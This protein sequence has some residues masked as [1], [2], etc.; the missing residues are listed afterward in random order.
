MYVLSVVC[1]YPVFLNEAQF[2]KGKNVFIYIEP[3]VLLPFLMSWT[4]G[5]TFFLCTH[6]A[7]FQLSFYFRFA[8]FEMKNGCVFHLLKGENLNFRLV[9][10]RRVKAVWKKIWR[11]CVPQTC[12]HACCVCAWRAQCTVRKCSQLCSPFPRCQRRLHTCMLALTRSRRSAPMT[13]VTLVSS[14]LSL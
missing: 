9:L 2:G 4:W 10:P 13:L 11:L 6:K 7:Y 3:L 8:H 12:R 1:H 5:S 14:P